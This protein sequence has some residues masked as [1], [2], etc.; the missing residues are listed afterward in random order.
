MGG[1]VDYMGEPIVLVGRQSF[2]QS[3]RSAYHE[4]GNA[5]Y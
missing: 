5:L 2:I 3:G 4:H 1:R